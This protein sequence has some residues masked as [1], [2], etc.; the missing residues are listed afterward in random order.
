M[1]WNAEG[2]QL[3]SGGNDNLLLIWDQNNADRPRYQFDDHLAAVKAIEWCPHQ[4]N[5][6]VSGGGTADRHIRFWNTSTGACLGAHDTKSQVCS[7]KWSKSHK[8]E[9]IS[10]HGFSQNQLTVW[11][12]PNMNK[13]TELSGHTQRVLQMAMS[14]D[15]QTVVSVA[16][17]ETLR[18]WKVF[19]KQNV[20]NT[21]RNRTP[22]L[23]G[24]CFIR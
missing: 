6:L 17:D 11:E 16:A 12:Y 1:K 8:N 4:P 24:N 13:L 15:G 20:R 19:E 18:F 3:A 22:A 2:T 9:L 23:A 21:K 14:P 7:I 10:S 5:L